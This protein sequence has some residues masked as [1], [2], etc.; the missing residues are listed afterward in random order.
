MY[1]LGNR[2][3]YVVIRN[4]VT[5]KLEVYL[6]LHHFLGPRLYKRAGHLLYR[7]QGGAL[8][9][10]AMVLHPSERKYLI[11]LVEIMPEH[12]DQEAIY[13]TVKGKSHDQSVQSCLKASPIGLPPQFLEY[14]YCH[15]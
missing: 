15:A 7:S 11:E 1:G 13:V 5:M 14:R 4:P 12:N 10:K 8:N 3:I 9:S 2:P 6:N